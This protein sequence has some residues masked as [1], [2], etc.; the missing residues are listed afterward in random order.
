MAVAVIST[1]HGMVLVIHR[2]SLSP[3]KET[4]AVVAVLWL[5][6]LMREGAVAVQRDAGTSRTHADRHRPSH[7]H[8]SPATVIVRCHATARHLV[9]LLVV[10]HARHHVTHRRRM[11][12]AD[13]RTQQ[14]NSALLRHVETPALTL[15][16]HAP[17]VTTTEPLKTSASVQLN[18][19][20]RETEM[21][22]AM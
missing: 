19:M 3:H 1:K 11:N 22:S 5:V 2:R 17:S 21:P 16:G 10:G 15:G 14:P 6:Q 12:L 4:D 18:K 20:R 9:N 13:A 8:S 7:A